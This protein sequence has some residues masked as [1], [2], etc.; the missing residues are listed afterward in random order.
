MMIKIKFDR[1]QR[2]QANKQTNKNFL[3]EVINFALRYKANV[4]HVKVVKNYNDLIKE[5]QIT[6]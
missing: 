3:N 5:K 4:T 2:Q 1:Q 6:Y